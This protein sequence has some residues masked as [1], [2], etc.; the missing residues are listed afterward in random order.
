MAAMR[1]FAVA[2]P[3]FLL[4]LVAACGDGPGDEDT[5]DQTRQTS[6]ERPEQVVDSSKQYTA[7]IKTSKGD[8]VVQLFADVAPNTVN[9]FVFLAQQ[10]FFDGLT[11]H[12]VVKDFVIQAGDPT[13]NGSGGPGYSVDD[14]PNQLSN[15]RGTLAM[16]KSAGADDFGSQFFINVGNNTDLDHDNP[17]GDKFYPFAEVTTGMEVVDA[18]ANSPTG[19]NG[20]P[21]PPITITTITIEER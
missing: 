8:I 2:F 5:N 17:R 19:A 4:A 3:L 21:N 9:S 20:R 18:I 14:E 1:Y 11:F 13:G 7:T 15:T 12:R 10:K 16:A 6:F